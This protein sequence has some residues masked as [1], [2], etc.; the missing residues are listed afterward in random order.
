MRATLPL[1]AAVA[2]LSAS[3]A[4]NPGGRP[5]LPGIAAAA[6]RDDAVRQLSTLFPPDATRVY[7]D[8]KRD[9]LQM[10]DALRSAGFAVADH[11]TAKA[12]PGYALTANASE[13]EAGLYTLSLRVGPVALARA[14]ATEGE[15]VSP[16]GAWTLDAS[17]AAAAT[18]E[19]AAILEENPDAF[20]PASLPGAEPSLTVVHADPGSPEWKARLRVGP[21]QRPEP[22]EPPSSPPPIAAADAAGVPLVFLPPASSIDRPPLPP[23]FG[24]PA[25]DA[26][27][28]DRIARP[29]AG[30]WRVQL[31]AYSQ[32]SDAQLYARH[33]LRRHNDVLTGAQPFFE[34]TGQRQPRTVL[35]IGPYASRSDAVSVC[36]ALRRSGGQCIV[37]QGGSNG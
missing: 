11:A 2:A 19:R 7:V 35:K 8:P 17:Q 1:V 28:L 37:S 14:Y 36:L 34:R 3:C 16:A 32:S 6:M 13:V 23:R 31:G 9:S 29:A 27:P 33:L 4:A 26:T 24:S 25:T 30:T 12:A 15:G 22:T 10:A 5:G 21:E 18:R 20:A